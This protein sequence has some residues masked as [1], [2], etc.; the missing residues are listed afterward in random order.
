MRAVDFK[1]IYKIRRIFFV[2]VGSRSAISAATRMRINDQAIK[3]KTWHL[4]YFPFK[5]R[6]IV[7]RIFGPNA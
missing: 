1:Q 6:V 4:K 7:F 2:F 5:I 3:Y